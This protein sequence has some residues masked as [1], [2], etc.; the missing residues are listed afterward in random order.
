MHSVRRLRPWPTAA[1]ILS[2][3]VGLLALPELSAAQDKAAGSPAAL[4]P[5]AKQLAE[6][7]QRAIEFLKTTQSDDGG[8]TT[9]NAPGIA[10]LVTYALLESGVPA[11][12]P[13]V[14]KAFEHLAGF[15]RL[16]PVGRSVPA[17]LLLNRSEPV[18]TARYWSE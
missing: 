11:D 7:R 12:D 1:L 9:P 16:H 4:G 17:Y 10:A 6:S 2:L 18:P 3:S 13:A 8:W 14:K 15:E 5:K